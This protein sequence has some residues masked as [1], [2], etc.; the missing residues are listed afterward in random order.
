MTCECPAGFIRRPLLGMALAYV[1]G[2]AVGLHFPLP[3]ALM[4]LAP[5]FLVLAYVCAAHR[6]STA[7]LLIA[8]VLLGQWRATLYFDLNSEQSLDRYLVRPREYAELQARILEAPQL[9]RDK[10]GN[11]GEVRFT[12]QVEKIRDAQGWKAMSDVLRVVWRQPP[13]RYAFA[14]GQRWRLHGV[15]ERSV[16][17]WTWWGGAHVMRVF[18]DAGSCITETRGF[19]WIEA[20][21]QFR[22]Y[23]VRQLARGVGENDLSARF[24]RALMLGDRSLLD[25]NLRDTFATTGMLHV[26]AVSGLHVGILAYVMMMFLQ[27]VGLD[28][29][30]A[31]LLV[32]GMLAGYMV[33]LGWRASAVRAAVMSSVLLIGTLLRRR[34]DVPSA[35]ALA[36]CVILF[37]CPAQLADPCF[38]LSFLAVLGLVI[39]LPK[40]E[41]V[42]LRWGRACATDEWSLQEPSWLQRTMASVRKIMGDTLLASLSVWLITAPLVLVWF[43]LFSPI[44]LIGNLLVIPL[45]FVILVT[46]LLSLLTGALQG[47]TSSIFNYANAFFVR[48]LLLWV[49]GLKQ[50]PGGFFRVRTFPAEFVI[51]WYVVLFLILT[52]RGLLKRLTILLA[53]LGVAAWVMWWAYDSGQAR[54]IVLE[55]TESGTVLISGPGARRVL[56]HSGPAFLAQ[57][58]TASLRQHGVGKLDVLVLAEPDAEH[59]GG[60]VE[61][62]RALHV[63]ELWCSP[64]VRASPSTLQALREARTQGARVRR[65]TRG[66]IIAVGP[67]EYEVLYPDGAVS[68]RSR[69]E[70]L[71]LRIQWGGAAAIIAGGATGPIESAILGGPTDPAADLLVLGGR[72]LQAACSPEWLEAVK[73]RVVVLAMGAEGQWIEPSSDWLQRVQASGATILRADREG[74]MVFKW[75]PAANAATPFSCAVMGAAPKHNVRPQK[76]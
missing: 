45:A 49:E 42:M 75:R 68:A 24:T 37:V 17:S 60:A 41:A 28:R 50:V 25:D 35:L 2:T 36:A 22:D 15:V 29:R 3:P 52:S 48:V 27:T 57:R 65:L 56:I 26:L 53:L 71:V 61:L 58:L 69:T 43:H 14:Y 63:K 66:D 39:V 12:A 10:E 74:E 23:A 34:P 64:W 59:V 1:A 51:L 9:Y 47:A 16:A 20:C 18:E 31:T 21:F 5:L 8:V 46:G 73:P 54:L 40:L 4:L 76:R 7:A 30:T 38:L 44:A 67:L 19:R 13:N 70:P 33:I 32:L 11:I 6:V 72:H 62:L 55:P